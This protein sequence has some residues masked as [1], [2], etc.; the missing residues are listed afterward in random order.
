MCKQ[1]NEINARTDRTVQ[2]S[3]WYLHFFSGKR[4]RSLIRDLDFID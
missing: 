2:F 1:N 4:N 3:F